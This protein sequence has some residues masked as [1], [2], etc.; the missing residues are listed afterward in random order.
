M[1]N[2]NIADD[3][4][5]LKLAVEVL[6]IPESAREYVPV[7]WY[8][9]TAEELVPVQAKIKEEGV[10]EYLH[11]EA[12]ADALREKVRKEREARVVETYEAFHG[13]VRYVVAIRHVG[14]E[15]YHYNAWE[16]DARGDRLQLPVATI[17]ALPLENM[18]GFAQR[19]TDKILRKDLEWSLVET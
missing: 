14:K 4:P 8:C 1:S 6:E 7:Y 3:G 16:E 5:E 2:D 12:T 17:A 11:P 18:R 19:Q 9:D 15:R 10:V 13:S